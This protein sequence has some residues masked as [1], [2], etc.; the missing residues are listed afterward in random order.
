ML[1]MPQWAV[2][3]CGGKIV[4]SVNDYR[5]TKVSRLIPQTKPIVLETEA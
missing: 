5:Y 1:A 4:A 3:R 2:V